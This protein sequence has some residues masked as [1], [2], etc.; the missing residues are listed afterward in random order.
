MSDPSLW[1]RQLRIFQ[2]LAG[3]RSDFWVLLEHQL[4]LNSFHR[5]L[6]LLSPIDLQSRFPAM[7]IAPTMLTSVL[8]S[9]LTSWSWI[10]FAATASS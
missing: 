7:F 1:D 9:M 6:C 5:H 2:P 3:L 10:T 4:L 8:T